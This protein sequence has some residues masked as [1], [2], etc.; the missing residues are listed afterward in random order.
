MTA[1]QSWRQH[2]QQAL[3]TGTDSN[4][5]NPPDNDQDIISNAVLSR[6]RMGVI[7]VSLLIIALGTIATDTT[8]TGVGFLLLG[9][10][11]LFE[12]FILIQDWTQRWSLCVLHAA[13]LMTWIGIGAAI[14]LF[15]GD[16]FLLDMT[17][18]SDYQSLLLAAIY[19]TVTIGF[20]WWLSPVEHKLWRLSLKDLQVSSDPWGLMVIVAL[21]LFW[22]LLFELLRSGAIGFRSLGEATSGGSLPIFETFLRQTALAITGF[23]G[24]TVGRFKQHSNIAAITL[25]VLF[26]PL[27][28]LMLLGL[29]RQPLTVH[30]AVFVIFYVW[31]RFK[32][33]QWRSLMVWAVPLLPLIFIGF[34]LFQA[35]R[36]ENRTLRFES[37]SAVTLSEGLSAA[38]GT[39][40]DDLEGALEWQASN[41]P[42]RMFLINY[43]KELMVAESPLFGAGQ[44]SLAEMVVSIPSIILPNKYEIIAELGGV[45]EER[46]SDFDVPDH[47]DYPNTLLTTSYIDFGWLGPMIGALSVLLIGSLLAFF[48]RIGKNNLFRLVVLSTTLSTFI[49]A[50]LSFY[51]SV[52]GEFRFLLVLLPLSY[53]LSLTSSNNSP[54]S[55]NLTS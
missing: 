55:P 21:A 8:I 34:L 16:P 42:Q 40:S 25:S 13:A 54:S 27:L 48:M 36:V 32:H 14:G 53:L 46:N 35:Q 23:L 28:L 1:S 22:V 17:E 19:M 43:L 10:Q 30:I 4:N 38:A 37:E 2:Q 39:I 51:T 33:I 26:I 24:W 3:S 15:W 6:L 12:L 29:G 31:A 5:T 9:L 50:E 11:G 18:A 52:T 49:S 20:L 47:L 41:L 7:L 44:A 45:S